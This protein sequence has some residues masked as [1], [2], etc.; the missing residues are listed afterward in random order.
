MINMVVGGVPEK[1]GNNQNKVKRIIRKPDIL[2]YKNHPKKSNKR[3]KKSSI[4]A[5]TT[6]QLIILIARYLISNKSW[7]NTME[8]ITKLLSDF[9]NSSYRSALTKGT[10]DNECSKAK[11]IAE[12]TNTTT[13][14]TIHDITNYKGSN[15]R[16]NPYPIKK[17]PNINSFSSIKGNDGKIIKQNFIPTY[18]GSCGNCWL[19]GLEVRFFKNNDYV[20]GCGECEHIGAIIASFL[21][22]ML[23]TADID[24]KIIYAYGISHVYCNR[25]KSN[26]ISVMFNSKTA[27]WQIDTDGV[28]KIVSAI[29]DV[30]DVTHES[31]YDSI[32]K[33]ELSA[34]IQILNSSSSSSSSSNFRDVRTAEITKVSDDWC[35]AANIEIQ[36][37]PN[38]K[39]V[40][41]K[42]VKAHNVLLFL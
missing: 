38:S 9:F 21:A 31:E 15:E 29:M 27:L 33:S 23:T 25:K 6:Q 37:Q 19:C 41:A 18:I 34:K 14:N 16:N 8:T 22:G 24:A 4:D 5:N 1:K 11:Q 26:T 36:P 7:K 13:T 20:T 28:E 3:T 12:R 30:S 2:T 42:V 40:K 10:P 39:V 17:Y 32:F 35:K